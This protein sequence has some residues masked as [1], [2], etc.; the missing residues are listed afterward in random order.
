MPVRSQPYG[1]FGRIHNKHAS[2]GAVHPWQADLWSA[3]SGAEARTSPSVYSFDEFLLGAVACGTLI[4]RLIGAIP[5]LRRALCSRAHQRAS[6]LRLDHVVRHNIA[7][8]LSRK[9]QRAQLAARGSGPAQGDAS[10][11][12]TFSNRTAVHVAATARAEKG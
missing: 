2:W 4:R 12:R 1:D 7:T 5:E 3:P 8:L 9:Q 6:S 10:A 11:L